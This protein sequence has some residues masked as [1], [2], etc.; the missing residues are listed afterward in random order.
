MRWIHVLWTDG[1]GGNI[2]HIAD[3]EVT[4]EE[5]EHVLEHPD[6]ESISRSSGLPIC[7]GQTRAGR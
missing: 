4:Q 3:N 6:Y 5:V 2:E 1:P 7:S